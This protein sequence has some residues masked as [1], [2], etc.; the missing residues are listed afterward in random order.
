MTEARVAYAAAGGVGPSPSVPGRGGG[1]R[2]S[3][4]R[5]Q[6]STSGT[7][8]AVALRARWTE[9]D[10]PPARRPTPRRR[11]SDDR[12][13]R[14]ARRRPPPGRGP[15]AMPGA[16]PRPL[17]RGPGRGRRRPLGARAGLRA[18]RR[19]PELDWSAAAAR[20]ARAAAVG[21]RC[22]PAGDRPG[23]LLRSAEVGGELRRRCRRPS[24]RGRRA[25]RGGPLPGSRASRA[26]RDEPTGP[27]P[28]S[29]TRSSAAR[30]RLV[31]ACDGDA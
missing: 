28:R 22:A 29:P 17:E 18:G 8:R 12:L 14:G 19:F 23:D 21:R 27:C 13:R 15:R 30:R 20:R 16:E 5:P 10:G 1:R 31:E 25:A 3:E 4:W 11:S 9:I 2:R 24:S 26:T 7:T 6:R